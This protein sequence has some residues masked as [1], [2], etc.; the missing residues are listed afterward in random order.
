MKNKVLK[1]VLV[2][3]ICVGVITGLVLLVQAIF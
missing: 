3:V 1:L 2:C